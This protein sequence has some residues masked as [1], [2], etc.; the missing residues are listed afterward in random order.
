[1]TLE[2]LVPVSA[3]FLQL[4]VGWG[5]EQNWHFDVFVPCLLLESVFVCMLVS[6]YC[7][8]HDFDCHPLFPSSLMDGH[9]ISIYSDLGLHLS[10]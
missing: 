8:Y 1:M 4:Y 9:S 7:V 3:Y 6:M 5:N 10:L 2:R